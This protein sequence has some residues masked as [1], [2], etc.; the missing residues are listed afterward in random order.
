M[1]ELAIV[2]TFCKSM[3]PKI[4]KKVSYSHKEQQGLQ[5]SDYQHK[6]EREKVGSLIIELHPNGQEERGNENSQAG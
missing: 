4:L 5:V 2:N 6:G 3:K 1:A